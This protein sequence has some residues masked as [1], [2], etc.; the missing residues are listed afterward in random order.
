[1]ISKKG[2]VKLPIIIFSIVL[3][4]QVF[5]YQMSNRYGEYDNEFN[6]LTGYNLNR[7]LT[8]IVKNFGDDN[9]YLDSSSISESLIFPIFNLAIIFV[10][11]PIPRIFGRINR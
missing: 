2:I 7:E 6:S 4:F 5:S 1:M 11:N 10:S 9:P 8:F 3:V